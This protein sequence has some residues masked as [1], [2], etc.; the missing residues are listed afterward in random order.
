MKV[1]ATQ[2]QIPQLE[3]EC[4]DFPLPLTKLEF[5]KSNWGFTKDATISIWRDDRLKLKAKIS[6]VLTTLKEIDQDDFIGQGNIIEGQKITG[7]DANNNLVIMNESI[8]GNTSFEEFFQNESII[9][10]V[11]AEITLDFIKI[12]YDDKINEPANTIKLE[13]FVCKSILARFYNST[14]RYS[15]KSKKRIRAGVDPEDN[16]YNHLKGSN[17]S[18]DFCK[19]QLEKLEFL[20]AKVPENFIPNDISGLC[21]EFREIPKEEN[22]EDISGALSFIS[23]LLGNKIKKIGYSIVNDTKLVESFAYSLDEYP[24]DNTMPPIRFNYQY[25]WGNF[26]YLLNTYLPKFLDINNELFLDKAIDKSFIAN[27][28]PIGTN[29]PILASALET[30]ISKYFQSKNIKTFEYISEKEYST[31]IA[32][33]LESIADRLK[34]ISG[35][36]IMLRKISGAFRK[37]VNEK[38][39]QFFDLIN[40]NVSRQ[41][42]KAINLR[43]K[44]A[45]GSSDYSKK[46]KVYKDLIASRV[47]EVLFNR[48][49]LKLL[50]YEGYYIDYS[51]KGTPLKHINFT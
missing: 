50:N 36:E 2:F 19:V 27:N 29:L 39:T 9:T 20:V 6:G 14:T 11:K 16:D 25:D 15:K 38:T 32:S 22:Y 42:L 33:E 48:V 49:V 10:K 1:N 51:L 34:H 12:V 13:W 8:I 7:R 31:I 46:S 44:M 17:T 28:V 5:E 4:I 21:F 3:W 35:H 37:G 18:R 43:N 45:H 26:A 23:F 30:I 47:Y 40:L 41:E 24:E